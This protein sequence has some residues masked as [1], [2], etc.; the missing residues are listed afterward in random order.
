MQ[1]THSLEWK[2][3]IRGGEETPSE[4][5]SVGALGDVKAEGADGAR[6]SV[7]GKGALGDEK[8]IVSPLF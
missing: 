3:E 2:A 8:E 1:M 5:G 7:S 6:S 4:L